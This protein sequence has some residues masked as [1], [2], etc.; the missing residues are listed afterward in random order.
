MDISEFE[1]KEA[2]RAKRSALE[3]FRAQI[4]ELKAKGYANWQIRDWL[5]ANGL[6]VSQ[7]AVRK[8]IKKQQEGKGSPQP[9]TPPAAT[10]PA[11]GSVEM[12]TVDC[13]IQSQEAQPPHQGEQAEPEELAGLDEK[14][15][16]EQ[17]ADKF[18]GKETE[19][20]NPLV[21]RFL[22]KKEQGKK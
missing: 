5:A 7:E 22:N 6:K 21:D 17:L 12:R 4:L 18:I 14:Q 1:Q 13:A 16:R 11:R 2:P 10:S 15:R 20:K 19:Q 8:F 3:P 9:A